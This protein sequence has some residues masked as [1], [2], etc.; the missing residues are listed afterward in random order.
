ML[1]LKGPLQVNRG[2]QLLRSYS[3]SYSPYEIYA[4]SHTIH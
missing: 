2:N 1:I 4:H 3:Y